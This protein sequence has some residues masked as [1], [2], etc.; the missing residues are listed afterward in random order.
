MSILA[1]KIPPGEGSPPDWDFTTVDPG[2]L[3]FSNTFGSGNGQNQPN[4]FTSIL[5]M[6]G[7]P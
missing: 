7:T 2:D 1:Y 5:V 4:P 3:A 6:T